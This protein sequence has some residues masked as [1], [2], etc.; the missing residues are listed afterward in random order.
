MTAVDAIQAF[1]RLREDY[2]RYYDTPFA[3]ADKRVQA[4]RK[5]LLDRDG[6][7]WREPWIEPLRPFRGSD[8]SLEEDCSAT[9]AHS[10]LASFARVGLIPEAEI[11]SLYAHQAESLKQALGGKNVVVTAG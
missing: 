5:R 7:A 9:G 10:D 1:E 3:L 4:E 2:F 6:V 11:K 8:V